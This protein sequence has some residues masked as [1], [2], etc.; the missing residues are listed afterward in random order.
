MCSVFGLWHGTAWVRLSAL[1]ITCV[2]ATVATRAAESDFDDEIETIDMSPDEAVGWSLRNVAAPV[3]AVFPGGFRYWY[4]E[5]EISI[6]TTPSGSFVDLFYVRRNFQKRFEQAEAPVKVLLPP[7]IKAS[8]RDA[9]IVRAFQEG[10][11]QQSVT[12]PMESRDEELLIH[13]EP[14]PNTL[15][16]VAHRYFADRSSLVFLTKES[17]TFRVTDKPGGFGLILNETAQ[18]AE[19]RAAIEGLASPMI[20]GASANQVGEDFVFS[21]QFAGGRDITL[22]SRLHHDA[23]RALY[24]FTLDLVPAAG[25]DDT[26]RRA[27]DALGRIESHHVGGCSAGFEA[28]LREQLDPGA[29]SRALTPKGDFTDRYLR[30]AMRRLGEVSP[31]E[32]VVEFGAGIAYRPSVPIELE[33]ALSQAGD[34]RGFVSLLRQFVHELEDE[35]HRRETFRSLV[36]P[37]LDPMTFGV[38]MEKAEAHE[39]ACLAPR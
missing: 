35:P 31:N 22:R 3:G 30:A 15:T 18:S 13:L 29:L 14:L 21:V 32:G 12:L 8:A 33:A 4:D 37:E 16:A 24:E 34:A 27:L 25:A 26:V 17:P 28:A 5:R 10:Y 11:R 1:I 38:I 19:A 36:A 9:L 39:Q 20:A 7:R 6:D 23:A 2:V